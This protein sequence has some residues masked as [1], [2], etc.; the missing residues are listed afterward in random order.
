LLP[1][2]GNERRG[3]KPDQQAHD[4]KPDELAAACGSED[5]NTKAK[6]AA[7]DTHTAKEQAA[8]AWR[9]ISLLPT[10]AAKVRL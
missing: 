8:I 2:A 3:Y 10:R 4:A 1:P 7:E 6:D 5:E 9:A